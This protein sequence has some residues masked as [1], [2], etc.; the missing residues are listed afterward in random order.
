MFIGSY[1][2]N[3]DDKNRLSIPKKWISVLGN[4]IILTTGLDGSIFLYNK[5]DW[6]HFYTKLASLSLLD[7]N[8]RD[9]S[10]FMLSNAFEIDVDSHNRILIPETL[11]SFSKLKSEI[12]LSGAGD[13]VEIWA[14]EI[15]DKII[16]SINKDADGLAEK[17]KSIQDNKL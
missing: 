3:L 9:F 13:R 11:K 8:S 14:K 17:I 15:F 12:T 16:I 10:R 2:H 1:T 4:K 6:D 7:K 5:K